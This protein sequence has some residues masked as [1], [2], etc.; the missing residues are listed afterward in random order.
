MT[1][2]E[3]LAN[4]EILDQRLEPF[5]NDLVNI[6]QFLNDLGIDVEG[7]SYQ[8]EFINRCIEYI[9]KMDTSE[10]GMVSNFINTLCLQIDERQSNN[11]CNY[12]SEAVQIEI[13]NKEAEVVTDIDSA[14]VDIKQGN[15]EEN[16]IIN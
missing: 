2:E 3:Y 8:D 1:K 13:S 7:E 6:S 14:E 11:Q 4:K 9:N 15:D 12:D 16:S 5:F 10:L